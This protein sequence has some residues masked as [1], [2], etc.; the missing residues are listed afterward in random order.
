MSSVRIWLV[1]V[2][3]L[4]C[5]YVSW[6]AITCLDNNNKLV[7]WFIVYKLPRLVD[8]KHEL[9]HKGVGQMYMDVN[10]QHWKLFDKA[11]TEKSGHA[12]YHTLQQVYSGYQ[13][14]EMAYLMY[15]DQPPIGTKTTNHGHTK[16]DI[17]FDRTSGFWLVHSVPHFPPVAS[18]GYSYPESGTVFGQTFLCVTYQYSQLNAIGRQLL[19]NYPKI[20]AHN[21]P[22]KFV[23]D[24]MNVSQAINGS[25]VREAPWNNLLTL[26]S[27][28]GQPFLSFAKFTTYGLDLYDAWLAPHFATSM[29]AETWRNG[30]EPLASN[31]SCKYHV[32]NVASLKLLDI[33]WKKTEDHAKWAVTSDKHLYWRHQQRGVTEASCWWNGVQPT[34]DGGT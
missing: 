6:S 14:T 1:A 21:L 12:V 18:D 24:N 19:Y 28:A 4:L 17:A 15:N 9:V 16:G 10:N 25:H 11:I 22:E 29:D 13:N 5:P 20:Y 23:H 27:S 3:T 31:C 2:S 32:L 8:S 30:G 33:S 7:D 26:T 34:V